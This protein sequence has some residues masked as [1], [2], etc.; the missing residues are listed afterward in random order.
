MKRELFADMM[1]FGYLLPNWIP[2]STRF[3]CRDADYKPSLAMMNKYTPYAAHCFKWW[4]DEKP[5]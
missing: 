1:K 2:L 5:R 3:A 4:Y